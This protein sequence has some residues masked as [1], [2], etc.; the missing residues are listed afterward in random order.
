M[1]TG[2]NDFR[3][4]HTWTAVQL[5]QGS[6][7]DREDEWVSVSRAP[8][9]KLLRPMTSNP[10]DYCSLETSGWHQDTPGSIHSLRPELDGFN[11]SASSLTRGSTQSR[12]TTA[13]QSAGGDSDSRPSPPVGSPTDPL[14]ENFPAEQTGVPLH[15]SDLNSAHELVWDSLSEGNNSFEVLS[16]PLVEQGEGVAHQGVGSADWSDAMPSSSRPS[17]NRSSPSTRCTPSDQTE[18][19]QLIDTD[20]PPPHPAGTDSVASH[21]NWIPCADTGLTTPLCPA[22]KPGSARLRRSKQAFNSPYGDS[23]KQCMCVCHC[24][25]KGG[26]SVP[27]LNFT[28]V[29]TY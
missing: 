10:E 9:K 28:H 12:C 24:W 20:C 2:W 11:L 13:Q 19:R 8:A 23:G 15:Q 18:Y 1:L 27:Y 4:V 25:F 14:L 29:C 21:T 26:S 22:R 6:H 7:K 5:P 16:P 3:S 17:D